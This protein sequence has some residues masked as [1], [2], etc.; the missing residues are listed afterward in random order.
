MGFLPR[1]KRVLTEPPQGRRDFWVFVS[2]GLFA[3]GGDQLFTIAVPLSV[4]AATESVAGTVLAFSARVAAYL[5]SPFIG[6]LIDSFDRRDVYILAQLYQ[7]LCLGLIALFLD[8]VLVLAVLVLLSG[9]GAVV[10]NI[11]SY[12][13]LVPRLVTPERRSKALSDYSALREVVK[14]VGPLSAGGIVV[15]AGGATALVF[16][17]ALFALSALVALFV[18]RVVI[19]E[20]E[21]A[22]PGEKPRRALSVGFSWLWRNGSAIALVATMTLANIGVGTLDVIFITL[23]GDSGMAA[24]GIGL[25]VSIGAVGAAAGTWAAGRLFPRSSFQRRIL[26]WQLAALAG[27]TVMAVPVLQVRVV[28]YV[29]TTFALGASNIN[30][31]RYRQESIP[32]AISGRVNSVMR[33]FITGA[34]P[35]SAVVFAFFHKW[36][37]SELH[38][39]PVV[40]FSALGVAVWAWYLARAG[41]RSPQ[42]PDGTGGDAVA[43]AD[44]GA[45]SRG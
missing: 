45:A 8:D 13:V 15:L 36:A 44:R 17:C 3:R 20:E 37:P 38:W 22:E 5:L 6:M 11:S 14:I 43:A 42:Q 16:T 31:I 21:P 25:V 39:T 41:R 29:I 28:G 23:L 32:M 26:Y 35:L 10:A 30:S 27:V 18:P 1:P 4:L 33:M 2:S 12:F 34:I 24:T 9:L 40:L 19:E 7:A